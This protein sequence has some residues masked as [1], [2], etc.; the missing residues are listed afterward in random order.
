MV[1]L[2]YQPTPSSRRSLILNVF[3]TSS[4]RR[5]LSR[6]LVSSPLNVLHF[7]PSSTHLSPGTIIIIMVIIIATMNFSFR[8][9]NQHPHH[10]HPRRN[11]CHPAATHSPVPT[12][13][14]PHPLPDHQNRFDSAEQ[15]LCGNVL[16]RSNSFTSCRRWTRVTIRV[17][18]Y[19]RCGF[20]A[21]DHSLRLNTEPRHHQH[22]P[23]PGHDLWL[24]WVWVH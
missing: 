15:E 12:L 16:S 10:R 7:A 9:S 6:S 1:W 22:L 11:S 8:S 24:V 17:R 14:T 4:Q 21:I 3:F 5:L 20:D 2:T 19:P 13:A 18:N 23:P